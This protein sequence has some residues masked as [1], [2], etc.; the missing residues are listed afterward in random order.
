MG[1]SER[2]TQRVHME[3]TVLN[4]KLARRKARS[5][6]Q[7]APRRAPRRMRPVVLTQ[8]MLAALERSRNDLAWMQ[9]QR[10]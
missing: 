5:Q 8:E 9:T 4:I 1:D 6:P 10:R 7:A 2:R 3:M